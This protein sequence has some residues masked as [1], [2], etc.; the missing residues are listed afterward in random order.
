MGLSP[1]QCIPSPAQPS[2]ADLFPCARL[3]SAS[4][5][6]AHPVFPM[7]DQ[8]W[9]PDEFPSSEWVLEI[10]F[11]NYD[12]DSLLLLS[13][14]L[15]LFNVI[16]AS[17]SM[18]PTPQSLHG[19]VL[20]M[21]SVSLWSLCRTC[22]QLLSHPTAAA[23]GASGPAPVTYCDKSRRNKTLPVLSSLHHSSAFLLRAVGVVLALEGFI[24][25]RDFLRVQ[26]GKQHPER[27]TRTNVAS[28]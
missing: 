23:E 2:T 20:A 11:L 13:L 21:H 17:G 5:S 1:A 14:L 4:C 10:M 22:P 15:L 3:L 16:F 7:Q 6:P 26:Y 27:A 25:L 12:D 24:N 9:G 8:I 18:S 28:Q 19:R